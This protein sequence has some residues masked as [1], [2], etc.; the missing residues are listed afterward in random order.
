MGLGFDSC[1]GGYRA[2]DRQETAVLPDMGLVGIQYCQLLASVL[3]CR[4]REPLKQRTILQAVGVLP[5]PSI[6][7]VWSDQLIFEI[8]FVYE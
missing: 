8:L 7:F 2:V 4:M 3:V 5:K 6:G 1:F